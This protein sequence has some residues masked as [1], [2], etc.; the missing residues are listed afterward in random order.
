MHIR[1][2]AIR[3]LEREPNYDLRQSNLELGGSDAIL[4]QPLRL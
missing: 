3:G 1:L 2:R 4:V